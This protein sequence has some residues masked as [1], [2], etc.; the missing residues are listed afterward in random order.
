MS[1]PAVPTAARGT[2]SGGLSHACDWYATIV[3]LAGIDPSSLPK[4]TAIDSVSLKNMLFSPGTASPRDSIV[5]ESVQGSTNGT[6]TSGKIRWREWNLYV[7]TVAC[8]AARSTE[9]SADRYL[10]NPG[11]GGYPKP[12]QSQKDAKDPE[13][14]ACSKSPCLFNVTASIEELPA[15]DVAKENPD[16]VATLIKM[17]GA[18]AWD[19]PDGLCSTDTYSGTATACDSLKKYGAFGPWA[20]LGPPPPPPPQVVRFTQGSFC[21]VHTPPKGDGDLGFLEMGDCSTNAARWSL[22][23]A[24]SGTEG[25]VPVIVSADPA[26][27]QQS[28]AP[29]LHVDHHDRNNSCDGTPSS[30]PTFVQTC[31]HGNDFTYVDGNIKN[32][33]CPNWGTSGACLVGSTVPN[34]SIG[35]GPCSVAGASWTMQPISQ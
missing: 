22:A 27:L 31:A 15:N 16:V 8:I 33:N 9:H 2:I 24:A 17:L 21:L 20:P 25:K 6:A 1:G 23:T 30:N 26:L 18:A 28:K 35:N 13:P 32:Q 4:S 14:D 29:C 5:H 34:A 11:Y 19:C 12:G 3:D 10:G 7:Q